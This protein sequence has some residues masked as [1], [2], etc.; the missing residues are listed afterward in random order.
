MRLSRISFTLLT[1]LVTT[2]SQTAIAA[3]PFTLHLSGSSEDATVSAS[4][5]LWL[6]G[7]GGDVDEAARWF[8]NLASGGDVVVLRA[9]GGAGYNDYFFRECGVP[10]NSVRS[11]VLHKREASEDPE[12]L[13]MVAQAEALFIAGGDQARYFENWVGTPLNQTINEHWA[14]GK[15]IG[16]TSAGL[17]IL[18]EF[19][20]L[21]LYPGSLDSPTALRDPLRKEITLARNFLQIPLLKGFLT[22]THF[23]ERSRLGRLAAFLQRAEMDYAMNGLIGLGIDEGTALLVEADGQAKVVSS[24]A[25]GRVHWVRREV[26][27]G[28]PKS[29]RV[30]VA[31]ASSTLDLRRQTVVQ[32]A[33]HHLYLV[34]D[35]KLV[36][37]ADPITK[38]PDNPAAAVPVP[39]K[40]G[41]LVSVGGAMSH[42]DSPI[43]AR[44][45][46]LAGGAQGRIGIVPAASGKPVRYSR[47]LLEILRPCQSIEILPLA[48]L[49]DAGTSD[50]DESQWL[51][52]RQNEALAARMSHLTGL[53]FLG[54]DQTRI[55]QILREPDGSWTAVGKAAQ[56]LLA[57]HGVIGGTSAGAAMMS[58][59][60]ITGGSTPGA[61][62]QGFTETYTSMEDQEEGALSLAPGSA[63]F[64][65]G[66]IDQHFDAKARLGRLALASLHTGLPGWGIAED[67]ALV[68][69]LRRGLGEVVGR[70]SVLFVDPAAAT[71]SGEPASYRVQNLR[72]AFLTEG[73]RFD[74]KSNTLSPHPA[75]SPTVG[76]EYY[77]IPRPRPT[78]LFS[79]YGTL[80]Q[81]LSVLLVD[82]AR[83]SAVETLLT[84]PVARNFDGPAYKITLSQDELSSGW[85]AYLD[86]T[87]NAHSAI[88]I[89]LDI[90]PARLT[91]ENR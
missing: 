60:M 13:R 21:A 89:R 71:F 70:A 55:L 54:G 29:L 82:N 1:L 36:D 30:W 12:V 63:F 5:G 51:A 39:P 85:W 40:Q 11:L 44:F 33:E 24:R 75:K 74:F 72:L 7:G 62:F 53:W 4:P 78:G 46:A 9:S 22:D 87:R 28:G 8:L 41:F 37:A 86:G 34:Q 15:P 79:P 3:G 49:D 68:V 57:R 73:D 10:L 18:G 31:D 88:G 38:L 77:A 35:E 43:L 20:F 64:P 67:T 23:S 80:D 26:L 2:S 58:D 45:L 16:G 14:Q 17:A 6:A 47:Q 19:A 27:P 84:D 76:S 69:D 59:P 25:G 90:E 42:R 81:A 65:Y 52:N 48:V 66:L 32:P 91:I 56:A 83:T 50:V 61:L